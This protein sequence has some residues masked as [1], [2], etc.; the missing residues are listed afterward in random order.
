MRLAVLDIQGREVA[1]LAEGTYA[2]GRHPVVWNGLGTTGG[3]RAGVFFLRLTVPGASRVQ[4]VVF[5]R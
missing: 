2:A 1:T 3:R 4:R 5:M